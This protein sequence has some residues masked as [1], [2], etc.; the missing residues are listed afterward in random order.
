MKK[1]ILLLA[2]LLPITSFATIIVENPTVFATNSSSEPSAIFMR[3]KNTS[4]QPVNLLSVESPLK[5]RLEMH[6]MKNK[7]MTPVSMIEVA[8]KSVT[9]LKRG[10]LH[11][12][13]FD[14][15]QP[16]KTGTDF[17]LTLYF[18]NGEIISIQAKTISR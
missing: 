8:P 18:D 4:T 15:A 5:S 3:L 7:K 17:P 1:Y 11:I 16:I 2:G 6:G 10:G 12:M 13:V 9:E 14:S